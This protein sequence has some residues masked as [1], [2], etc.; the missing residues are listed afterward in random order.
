MQQKKIRGVTEYTHLIRLCS[1]SKKKSPLLFMLDKRMKVD[2][3]S[4]CELY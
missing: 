2:W 4:G 1:T 3:N